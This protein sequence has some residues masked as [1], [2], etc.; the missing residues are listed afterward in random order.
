MISRS[1]N[2][3]FESL[4]IILINMVTISMMSAKMVALRLLEIKVFWKKGY[5]V[6]NFVYDVTIIIL[7][8]DSNYIV[9]V[10]MWPKFGKSIISMKEVI[11]TS[12]L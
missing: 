4:R 11:I 10:F 1:F 6:I 3:F 2:F 7:S 8:R 5:D 9:N 12:I